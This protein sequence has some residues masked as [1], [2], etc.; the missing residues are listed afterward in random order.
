MI[1]CKLSVYSHFMRSNLVMGGSSGCFMLPLCHPKS[2][3]PNLT[4]IYFL[5]SEVLNFPQKPSQSTWP[6]LPPSAR[7]S[8]FTSALKFF[9]YIHC[10]KMANTDRERAENKHCKPTTQ[11][12]NLVHILYLCVH[13]YIYLFV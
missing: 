4:F 3:S 13:V 1:F 6:W 8:G 7:E 11:R 9:K 5:P 10:R 2:F 12:D